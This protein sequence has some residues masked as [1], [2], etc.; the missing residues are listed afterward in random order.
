[1]ESSTL[2]GILIAPLAAGCPNKKFILTM[3][4]VYSWCDSWIDHNINRPPS[5]SSP[6]AALDRIRLRVDDI[7]PTTFDKPL[8]ERG[9]PSLVC[10]FQLWA[11]HNA[12]VLEAVP[13]ARLLV[14]E[15]GRILDQAPEIAAWAGVPPRTLRLDRGWLFS[16][17]QKHGVLATL[18]RSYVQDTADR[19]CG[20]LMGRYFPEVSWS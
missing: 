17:P 16:T 1:M 8:T 4:D 14:I 11:S 12:R 9:L 15:T 3:R 5:S 20:P 10:Y 13:S 18:D 19:I 7:E 6:W 2:A